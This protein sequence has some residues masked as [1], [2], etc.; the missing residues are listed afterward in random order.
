MNLLRRLYA[1]EDEHIESETRLNSQEKVE[2]VRLRRGGLHPA[3]EWWRENL[4]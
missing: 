1:M 2:M 4:I 3:L